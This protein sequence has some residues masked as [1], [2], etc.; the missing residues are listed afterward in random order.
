MKLPS[1]CSWMTACSR[2]TLGSRTTRLLPSARPIVVVP[3][4]LTTTSPCG[5][6]DTIFIKTAPTL[7]RSDAGYGRAVTPRWLAQVRG[8]E[9]RVRLARAR[10]ARKGCPTDGPRLAAA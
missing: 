4:S 10:L 9:S 6:D 8:D 2:E 5:L 3:V 7:P 1:R